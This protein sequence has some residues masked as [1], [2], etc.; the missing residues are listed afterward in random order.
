F[1]KSR[2][3]KDRKLEI[4]LFSPREQILRGFWFSWKCLQSLQKDSK[5]ELIFQTDSIRKDLS[6]RKRLTGKGYERMVTIKD[7]AKAANVSAMTVS[8]VL[9][10]RTKKVSKET[11]ERIERLME[12]MQYVPN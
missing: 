2:L 12:E 4:I 6:K 7:I 10:G 8:N 1:L 11:R 9:H 3:R 5:I